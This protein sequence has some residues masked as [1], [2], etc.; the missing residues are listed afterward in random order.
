MKNSY[1]RIRITALL[2][3]I[4]FVGVGAAHAAPL[5]NADIIKMAQA[6]LSE[7]I[8]ITAV[9]NAA[10]NKFD[11]SADALVALTQAKV[12]EPVIAALIKRV[13]TPAAAPAAAPVVTP[14]AVPAEPARLP[15]PAASGGGHSVNVRTPAGSFSSS[16]G[17]G[18]GNSVNVRAPFVSVGVGSGGGAGATGSLVVAYDAAFADDAIRNLIHTA[19]QGRG[20]DIVSDAP[21]F[22]GLNYKGS[23][24]SVAY[25]AGT[26]VIT[27][28]GGHAKS[29]G[30]TRSL[31]A[32]IQKELKKLADVA[33]ALA[34]APEK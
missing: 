26:V 24:A 34:P 20:W 17:A 8:I 27:N 30:W 9:E 23:A 12:S 22:V 31:R 25:G 28:Q 19:A 13:A 14:A 3:A 6:G 11:A 1:H 33:A 15:P 21:G 2:L 16:S 18:G 4:L 7:N 10:D 29:A 32:V 5:T